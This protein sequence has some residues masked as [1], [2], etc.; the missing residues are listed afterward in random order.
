MVGVPRKVCE[1]MLRHDAMPGKRFTPPR[2]FHC[3]LIG[4][5]C[6]GVAPLCHREQVMSSCLLRKTS[7]LAVLIV[8]F[9]E[10]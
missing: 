4:A 8:L 3:R 2:S 1:V 7:S 6:K 10:R 5:V 9:L